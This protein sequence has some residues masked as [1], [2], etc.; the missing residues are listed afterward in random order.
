LLWVPVILLGW[1]ADYNKVA[2]RGGAR[3]VLCD[4]TSAAA[5][6]TFAPHP[7]DRA[8]ILRPYAGE[9]VALQDVAEFVFAG[10]QQCVRC[11]PVQAV[12]PIK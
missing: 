6:P 2:V 7:Q 5:S 10:Q 4:E 12:L 3:K 9:A 8:E 11:P 1:R